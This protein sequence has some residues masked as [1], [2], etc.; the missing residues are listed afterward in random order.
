V[1]T[2]SAATPTPLAP[3][4]RTP[5][6]PVID[7]NM[8]TEDAV[9]TATVSTTTTTESEN[10]NDIDDKELDCYFH[11]PEEVKIKEE[12]WTAL[13]QDYLLMMAEREK[14]Q[15]AGKSAPKV[16]IFYVLSHGC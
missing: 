12:I 4:R 3:T 10:F 7:K 15:A 14:E 8:E 1:Q 2:S 5:S 6:Q 11:T 9:T 13:N 16:R